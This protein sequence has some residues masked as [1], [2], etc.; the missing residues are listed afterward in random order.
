[1]SD[2]LARG[3]R[4]GGG[5]S[6]S[7]RAP[8]GSRRHPL[9]DEQARPGYGLA[10]RPCRHRHLLLLL[11][12]LGLLLK[13]FEEAAA[14]VAACVA[15]LALAAPIDVEYSCKVVEEGLKE[16]TIACSDYSPERQGCRREEEEDEGG[17]KKAFGAAGGAEQEKLSRQEEEQRRM[18]SSRAPRKVFKCIAFLTRFFFT[19][20][21]KHREKLKSRQ[22]KQLKDLKRAGGLCGFH[23]CDCTNQGPI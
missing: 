2:A 22:A 10:C 7:R 16:T 9:V 13:A 17:G 6:G 1:M 5:R 14:A 4:H 3:S 21:E 18:P 19:E 12:L 8:P 15:L 20:T 23:F 11:L